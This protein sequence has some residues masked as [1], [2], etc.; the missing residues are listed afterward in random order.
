[1]KA[2]KGSGDTG[3]SFLTSALGGDETSASRPGRFTPDTL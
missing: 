3:P 2:Y 1:M